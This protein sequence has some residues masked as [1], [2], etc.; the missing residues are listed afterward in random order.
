MGSSL[1]LTR[2][3]NMHYAKLFPEACVAY[4]E[5]LVSLPSAEEEAIARQQLVNL[6]D[7]DA[8]R[9]KPATATPMHASPGDAQTQNRGDLQG[10]EGRR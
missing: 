7:F 8:G 3:F 4:R 9:G 5:L 1:L 6:R 10:G 2:A